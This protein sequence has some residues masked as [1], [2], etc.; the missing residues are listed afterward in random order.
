V[1]I[2]VGSDYDYAL[3]QRVFSSG[4]LNVA[5]AIGFKHDIVEVD[6]HSNPSSNGDRHRKLR[7]GKITPKVD[8]KFTCGFESPIPFSAIKKIAR[9]QK[10][11][12]PVLVLSTEDPTKPA[13]LN[14]HFCPPNSLD[15]LEYDFEDVETS[16][17]VILKGNE[18]WDYVARE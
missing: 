11:G 5:K 4:R 17:R 6:D 16:K 3:Q 10:V 1:R 12:D 2:Q 13:K 15:G 7:Y 18:V 8:A 9:G 14:S